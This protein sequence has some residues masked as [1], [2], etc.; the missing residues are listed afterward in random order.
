MTYKQD[1][2]PILARRFFDLLF[3]IA[4]PDVDVKSDMFSF[5]KESLVHRTKLIE[6][7]SLLEVAISISKNLE[8][9][10]TDGQDF[11]DGSD[12][13]C[14]SA[15]WHALNT[16]YSAPI[17]G[18]ANKRGLLRCVI[19]ERQQDKFYFFLIPH[20]AYKHIS[21]VG[22]IDIPFKLDGSPYRDAK[23]R[24]INWW[25]FEVSN[26]NG[27]LSDTPAT[28]INHKEIRDAEK[29]KKLNSNTTWR[30]NI[31]HRLE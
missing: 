7:G 2:D 13:K 19:Y 26:F 29:L 22:N 10:D 16:R 17:C 12:A 14:A 25:T 4:F 8:R 28:F 9:Y 30:T 6:V 27:I 15:R 23:V 11:V 31:V 3:P 1:K 18:V 21:N 5:I 20:D 24:N